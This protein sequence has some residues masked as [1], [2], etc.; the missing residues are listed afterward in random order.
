MSKWHISRRRMLKGMGAAIALPFL[1]AMV[2]PGKS[3]YNVSKKPVRFACLFMPNGVNEH[4]WTPAQFGR[5][6]ELSPALTSLGKLKDQIIIMDQMMNKDSIF[7]GADGH[8][9]KAASILTCTPIYPTTGDDLRSEGISFDQLIAQKK[10]HETLFDSLQYGIDRIDSGINAN[11]GYTRM[12]GSIISWKTP[13]Q[14]CTR[15]IEPRMAFDRLFRK[16]LPNAKQNNDAWKKSVLD[17]VKNDADELQRKLGRN[18]QDKLEEYLESIRSIEKRMEDEERL[19]KFE[20]Q[21]TPEMKRE[22]LALNNRIEAS[23]KN[24]DV[25]KDF[26]TFDFAV[27]GS[28]ALGVGFDVTEKTR[29]ML[30]IMALAFW[31]DSTRVGTYMFGNELSNRNFSFLNGVNGGH[32][33]ISHHGNNTSTLEQYTLINKWHVEQYAYFL[34]RLTQLKEG[35]SNI[36]DNSMIMLCSGLR[37]GN[38]HSPYNL[39][40]VLA[41]KAGGRLSTGQNVHLSKETPLSN[42]Y[43]TMAGILDMPLKSFADSTGELYDIH[44]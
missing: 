22:I 15:E 41:G 24:L 20:S 33:Q 18:D 30:D 2:P 6:F 8:Y 14:P 44:A 17:I 3:I 10:G 9:A 4:T 13:T 38:V 37:D 26:S 40:I 42:L 19:S 21:I 27:E 25:E 11:V 34:D 23:G 5:N 43:L 7:K 35:D 16:Y 32:H 31:S 1:Q 12:Y 36:L 39:P 28:T 29:Q